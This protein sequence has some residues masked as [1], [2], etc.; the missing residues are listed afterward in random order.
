MWRECLLIAFQKVHQARD[1]DDDKDR[2]SPLVWQIDEVY[3]LWQDMDSKLRTSAKI[4]LV[5]HHLAKMAHHVLLTFHPS[6]PTVIVLKTRTGRAEDYIAAVKDVVQ[7]ALYLILL[8]SIFMVALKAL[9][10]LMSLTQCVL[11]VFR[12]AWAVV[13]WVSFS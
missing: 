4:Q 5:V 1:F 8:L 13:R 12:L 6:S 7:A 3:H 9:K 11:V 10:V 2:R